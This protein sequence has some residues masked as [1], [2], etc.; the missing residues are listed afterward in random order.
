MSLK[1]NLDDKATESVLQMQTDIKEKNPESSLSHSSLVSWIVIE[2]LKKYFEKNKDKI[3]S[4]YFNP[5]AFLRNR[6][7][8]L[9]SPEKLE[10]LL[11]EVRSKVKI[12]RNSSSS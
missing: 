8:D 10:E 4:E 12:S 2:F 9:D 7:K 11:N 6:M 3:A 5:K 1:I